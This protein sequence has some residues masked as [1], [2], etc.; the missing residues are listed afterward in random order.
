MPF[1]VAIADA[2]PD[3][4]TKLVPDDFDAKYY[5]FTTNSLGSKR[6]S[7]FAVGADR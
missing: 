2:L 3:R 6:I 5:L 7:L 1:G 4:L